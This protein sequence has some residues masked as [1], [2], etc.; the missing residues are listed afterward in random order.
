MQIANI[1]QKNLQLLPQKYF[2]NSI[3]VLDGKFLSGKVEEP[4]E[5]IKLQKWLG[6]LM[7]FAL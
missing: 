5:K 3:E 1:M 6:R 7:E 4:E 2:F